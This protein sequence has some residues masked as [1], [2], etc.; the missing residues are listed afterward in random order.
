M[1]TRKE[2][3]SDGVDTNIRKTNK[4]KVQLKTKTFVKA[5]REFLK[6]K[7][8]GNINPEWE[9]SL[10]L[11]EEYFKTF[12]QLTYELE[13]LD[14]LLTESGKLTPL[15][16]ARDIAARRLEFIMRELGLTFKSQLKMELTEAVEEESPINQFIKGKIESR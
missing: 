13:G 2:A 4:K 5:A 11:L 10:M 1:R 3:A 12:L 6:S 8:N 14:S 16:G 15:Y 7:N 9:A